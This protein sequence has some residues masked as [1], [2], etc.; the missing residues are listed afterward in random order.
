VNCSETHLCYN[1]QF[2]QSNLVVTGLTII[3]DIRYVICSLLF[4]FAKNITVVGWLPLPI[5]KE[6]DIIL[7]IPNKK[8]HSANVFSE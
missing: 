6:N 4:L 8:R 3:T 1:Y 5:R 7:G 2:V